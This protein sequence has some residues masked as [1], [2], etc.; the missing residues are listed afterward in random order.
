[1]ADGRHTTYGWSSGQS[2][3]GRRYYFR[4]WMRRRR[5]TKRRKYPSLTDKKC[6]SGSRLSEQIGRETPRG[7]AR[8]TQRGQSIC[9]I[10][11]RMASSE[12]A[13]RMN[14]ARSAKN[15]S[16]SANTGIW[17]AGITGCVKAAT[18]STFQCTICP[19]MIVS[20]SFLC[21]TIGSFQEFRGM[22]DTYGWVFSSVFL[23]DLSE[24]WRRL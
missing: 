9:L 14:I 20:S 21:A 11:E 5:D 10:L 16:T 19:S 7:P 12:L 8:Y 3:F 22:T 1:M 18:R 2:G 6:T 4:Q 17:I 23:A 15:T 24:P 13:G